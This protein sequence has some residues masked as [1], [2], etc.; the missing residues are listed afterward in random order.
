MP[1]PF[2]TVPWWAPAYWI[3]NCFGLGLDLLLLLLLRRVIARVVVVG[4]INGKG[5]EPAVRFG[6]RGGIPQPTVNDENVIH[7][8]SL[9]RARVL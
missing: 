6:V 7:P 2:V 4:V 1:L 3:P 8:S 5:T 9:I